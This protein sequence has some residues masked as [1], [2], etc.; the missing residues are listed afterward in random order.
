MDLDTGDSVGMARITAGGIT[1][2]RP[3]L[4]G[5]KVQ[6]RAIDKLDEGFGLIPV[7]PVGEIEGMP[8]TGPSGLL[9]DYSSF[10][11]DRPVYDNL[12]DGPRPGSARARPRRSTT[13]C[14]RPGSASGRRLAQ[15][16]H[17]LDQSAYAL[18]LR[19]YG[20]VAALV[21]DHGTGRALRQCR[22]PAAGPSPRRRRAPRG[23]G[24]AQRGHGGG[25]ARAG[26]RAGQCGARRHPRRVAGAV[27]RAAHDHARLRRRPDHSGA[28]RGDLTA[29]PA[30]CWRC[31]RPPSSARW[32]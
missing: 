7:D 9:V 22:R 18:A 4:A 21:A 28:G 3:A 29:A 24:A 23:R 19:L 26:G 8:F 6:E 15:E 14:P 17:V 30:W 20:V 11:T 10:I 5:P 32:R 25:G 16:R 2:A 31:S 13:R 27:G 1:R 12:D